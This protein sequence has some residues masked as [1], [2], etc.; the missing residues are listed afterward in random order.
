MWRPREGVV[1]AKHLHYVRRKERDVGGTGSG[2]GIATRE[3]E[4][5]R[6]GR[7]CPRARMLHNHRMTGSP[8]TEDAK[9]YSHFDLANE[10]ALSTT[11][12]A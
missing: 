5:R 12:K 9:Q 3:K 4:R 11:T 2:S 7:C 8:I 1:K 6:E 10:L